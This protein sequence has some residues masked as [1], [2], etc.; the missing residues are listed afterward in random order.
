MIT[1]TLE[2]WQT[3]SW[4]DELAD[5]ITSP[6]ELF[7]LLKLDPK[8]LAG[9][10]DASRQFPLRTTRTYVRRIQIGNPHDP[11]LRQILPLGSELDLVPGYN[12]DPLHEAET[13]PLPGLIHKYQGRVLFIAAPQCAINCRYCFRRHFPYQDNSP[14]R[15]QWEAALDYIRRDPSIEE[16]IYSGGDPLAIS[17]R[18]LLWL[19][20]EVAAIDHVKRL[21]VHTRLP[22]VAPSR[23][24]DQCLEWLT[25]PQLQ[26]IVVIH[27]NHAQEIDADVA[28]ALSR[29]KQAGITLFN[30]SVLLRGVNDNSET[31]AQLSQALFRVGVLPY[32]LHVLDQVSGAAHFAISEVEASAIYQRLLTLL[33]GYLV[34]KLVRENA[35][36]GSKTPLL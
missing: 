9:A 12:K 17:D 27:C 25:L 18:Q 11:L 7:A 1:R 34:P 20:R 19:S 13:N 3:K 5:L 16:V 30:Q 35:G 26:T 36:A 15:P 24:T 32:Y 28:E 23:I 22:I 2:T 31:L 33:P 6:D 21:R 29:L 4:Q 8:D 10:I 14:G